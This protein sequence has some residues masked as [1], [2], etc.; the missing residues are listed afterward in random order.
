MKKPNFC[1]EKFADSNIKTLEAN[2]LSMVIGASAM[3][4]LCSNSGD[5]DSQSEN[6]S[7]SDDT[8]DVKADLDE[9]GI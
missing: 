4:A 8:D 1:I 9:A 5:S 6:C 7:L 3:L 2:E